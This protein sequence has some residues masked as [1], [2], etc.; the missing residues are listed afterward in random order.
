[1]CDAPSTVDPRSCASCRLR[2]SRADAGV[3]DPARARVLRSAGR[4]N[5]SVTEGDIAIGTIAT[6]RIVVRETG[7]ATLFGA[8][9]DNL[10]HLEALLNVRIRTQGHDLFVEGEPERHGAR[11]ALVVDQVGGLLAEGHALSEPT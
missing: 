9:D 6:R 2:D 11:R 4:V 7:V 5:S 8:Y 1:M 10:R 3:L